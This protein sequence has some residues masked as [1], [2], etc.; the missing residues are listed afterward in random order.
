M[1]WPADTPPSVVLA[2]V[3]GV[4]TETYAAL[5]RQSGFAVSLAR[6]AGDVFE[7]IH[8]QPPACILVPYSEDPAAAAA[9]IRELKADHAYG[10][11]PLILF[12]Q[13]G[14]VAD[15]AW[16]KVQADDY[17]LITESAADVG[18]RL[19]LC[20]ERASRDLDANPLTALPGNLT[21][22]REA[23]RRILSGHPFAMGYIDLDNF[24][25]FNDKYGFSRGDEVLRMTSRLLVNAVRD[26]RSTE[27][28]VGH[29]GGDDFIFM[30]PSELAEPIA[31]AITHRFDLVVPNFYDEEDRRSKLI[32]SLD[33]QGTRRE[34]PLMGCSIAIVDT[35]ASD[36]RHV[37]E[38]S[39][40]AADVKKAAKGATG[41]SYLIDRRR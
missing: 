30:A 31:V 4:S 13:Q 23:E 38:L 5:L 12:I 33:R 35:A 27:T 26:V 14:H 1:P 37:G 21:I 6:G 25:P 39:T 18:S 32:I 16:E 8:I 7:A 41:S 19:R 15:M 9:I 34:F 36:I 2:A 24:K 20:I 29:V 28:Y 22:M 17:L 10:H 40:R 3:E 11:L